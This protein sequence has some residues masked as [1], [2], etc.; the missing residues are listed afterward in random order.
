MPAALG[1]RGKAS[2]E[3]GNRFLTVARACQP[4]CYRPLPIRSCA[5]QLLPLVAHQAA[6]AEQSIDLRGISSPI[7]EQVAKSQISLPLRWI[8]IPVAGV[9]LLELRT[10]LRFRS[11]L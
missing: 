7:G 5:V 8:A 2:R 11:S 1:L 9:E 10:V 6:V 4:R 3:F